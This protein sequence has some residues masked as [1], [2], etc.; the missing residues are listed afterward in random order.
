MRALCEELGRPQDELRFLHV[1]GTNGKSSVTLLTAALLEAGGVRAGACV[2][3]HVYRWRERTRLAGSELAAAPFEAATDEVRAGIERLRRSVAEGEAGSDADPPTQFEAAIAISLVALRDAGVELAVIEAGLGGRLD[4]TNVIA[5][6]ATS[7]TSVALDHTDWLGTTPAMI[8]DEKLAVL[9]P[10][11]ALVLGRLEP[12]IEGRARRHAERLG[13][14]AVVAEP[15]DAESV[16]AGFGP[17][18]RR[19]AGVALELAAT[20]VERP[21][22]PEATRE[23]L[24]AVRLGGRLELVPGDPPLLIDAA[25]NEE[26]ARALAEALVPFGRPRVACLSVLADK[27]AAAIGAALSTELDLAVCTAAD[28][29]PAIG[30]PGAAALAPERLAEQLHAAGIE[31]EI[32]IDPEAALE[33]A[34]AI[35]RDRGGLAIC[36]GSNYLLRHA[37]TVRRGQ[38]CSR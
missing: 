16:P 5:S 14:S 25:H 12:E 17:Y 24:G 33:R 8:A 20:A 18:L 34:M 4:A 32:E 23:T 6:E 31:I 21:A 15:A 30:R 9:E 11:T 27:D 10:G 36:A 22:S 26:G 13:A 29:P 1:V 37:W 3:P 2:S 19:N 35:A 38:S 7:L 28:P